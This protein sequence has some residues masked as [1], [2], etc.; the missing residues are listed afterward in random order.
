M[1]VKTVIHPVILFPSLIKI[2]FETP[3]FKLFCDV[4]HLSPLHSMFIALVFGHCVTLVPAKE[5]G[6]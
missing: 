6:K 2:G 1:N 3:I 4:I 5:K